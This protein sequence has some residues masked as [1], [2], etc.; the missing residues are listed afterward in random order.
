MRG[1]RSSAEA[2]EERLRER[3][4]ASGLLVLEVDVRALPLRRVAHARG[5]A[6]EVVL[7]VVLPPE[8]QVAER[9]RG[10][11]RRREPFPV[12]DA[13]RGA[14]SVEERVGLVDEPARVPELE[15]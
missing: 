8:A 6:I 5:P 12:R 1:P 11:G 14:M 15:R 3:G 4:S 13:E 10:L 7:A 9:G 2:G